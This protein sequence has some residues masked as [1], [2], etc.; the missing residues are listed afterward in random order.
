MFKIASSVNIYH[1]KSP[2]S[3]REKGLSFCKQIP[4][5]VIKT[6]AEYWLRWYCC[7]VA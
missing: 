3:R 1:K 5:H 2:C 4:S 7:F 6:R